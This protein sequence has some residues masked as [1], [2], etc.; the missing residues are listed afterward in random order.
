[1]H[2]WPNRRGCPP[3][4]ELARSLTHEVVAKKA[5]Q[6]RQNECDANRSENPAIFS[7]CMVSNC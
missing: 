2:T 3:Y 4:L 1:M 6:K 7:R 5:N